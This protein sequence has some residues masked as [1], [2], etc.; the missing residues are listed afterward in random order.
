MEND[1]YV[2][3]K[4]G[5]FDG[6]HSLELKEGAKLPK[7]LEDAVVI[8]RQDIFAGPGLFSY[9]NAIQ[10]AIDL[11]GAPGELGTVSAL[12]EL[13]KLEEL[14]DFFWEQAMMASHEPNKKVPD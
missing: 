8:R 4:R 3:F 14:R 6:I 7:P 13:A 1:K 2:V 10:T 12:N 11:I 9:A 5:E